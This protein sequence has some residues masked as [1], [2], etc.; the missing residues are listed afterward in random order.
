MAFPNGVPDMAWP[1]AADPYSRVGMA[2]ES[3]ATSSSA[4][5]PCAMSPGR[6][7]R[8]GLLAAA[9]LVL[10]LLGVL[11]AA[12]AAARIR[13]LDDALVGD[14]KDLKD[15]RDNRVR[16]EQGSQS[17]DELLLVH[18]VSA[19]VQMV[20]N[21]MASWHVRSSFHLLRSPFVSTRRIHNS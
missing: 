6:R 10:L 11:Q 12:Q 15:I 20:G 5:S 16:P 21:F 4:A 17:K 13:D 2:R 18:V 7:R 3:T 14:I 1:A 9:V 8:G 19:S